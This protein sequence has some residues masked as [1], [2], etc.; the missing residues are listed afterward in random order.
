MLYKQAS[1]RTSA[2]TLPVTYRTN[3]PHNRVE[4]CGAGEGIKQRS[5]KQKIVC[6]S[7][8]LLLRALAGVTSS[9]GQRLRVSCEEL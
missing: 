5:D 2:T 9:A 8:L 1:G 3:P 7:K 6:P 4:T